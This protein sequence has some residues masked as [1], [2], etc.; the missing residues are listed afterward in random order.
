M[1]KTAVAPD[2]VSYDFVSQPGTDAHLWIQVQNGKD[3][4][5][6]R[7]GNGQNKLLAAEQGLAY[8]VYWAG[9]HA[10]AYRLASAN[11]TAMYVVSPDGGAPHKIADVSAAYGFAQ[12]N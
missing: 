6:L 3:I 2:F 1:T 11:G 8:P 9:P 5:L 4:L 12:I 7:D 10:A